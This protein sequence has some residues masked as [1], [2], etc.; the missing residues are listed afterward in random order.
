MGEYRQSQAL[1]RCADRRSIEV[2]H[3]SAF[4]LTLH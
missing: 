2:N 1:L 3:L 4:P